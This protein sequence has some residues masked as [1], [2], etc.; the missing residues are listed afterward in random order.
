MR[1]LVAGEKVWEAA[2]KRNAAFTCAKMFWWYNMYS[3]ADWS[4]TPRPMYPAD[5]FP[6]DQWSQRDAFHGHE[7]GVYEAIDQRRAVAD[8]VGLLERH[9]SR[10]FDLLRACGALARLLPEVDRLWGVPQP[11]AH[12]PEI[13]TGVH[14]ALVLDTAVNA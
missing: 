7:A 3:S 2:R 5:D 4:A 1:R 11:A 8:F 6:A 14:L 9:P 12:H 10:M 13:D